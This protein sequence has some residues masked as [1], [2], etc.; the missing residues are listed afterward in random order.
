MQ[1]CM[2]A[3]VQSMVS[4]KKK[5]IPSNPV[6]GYRTHPVISDDVS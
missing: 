1:Q 3:F 5:K 6:D 2:F 4:K